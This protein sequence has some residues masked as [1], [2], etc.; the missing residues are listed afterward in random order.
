MSIPALKQT[1]EF[2]KFIQIQYIKCINFLKRCLKT[3]NHKVHGRFSRHNDQSL[4][5]Y[6]QQ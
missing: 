5:Q 6:N 4:Q 1:W 2:L 3:I